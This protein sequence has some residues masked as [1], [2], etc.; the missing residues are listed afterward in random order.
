[1]K[2]FHKKNRIWEIIIIIIIIFSKGSHQNNP[3]FVSF[4]I[5]QGV[6]LELIIR[7]MEL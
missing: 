4:T 2:L 7:I 6:Q 5:V 3:P 1:V